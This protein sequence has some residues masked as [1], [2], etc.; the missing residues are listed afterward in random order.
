M[1]E[2]TAEAFST[3]AVF[4]YP[5]PLRTQLEV[6]SVSREFFFPLLPFTENGC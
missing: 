6:D 1:D 4:S 3:S 5:A 2:E